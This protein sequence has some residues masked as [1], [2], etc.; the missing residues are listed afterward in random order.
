MIE[1]MQY[2][3][4][5]LRVFGLSFPTANYSYFSYASSTEFIVHN[6]SHLIIMIVNDNNIIQTIL[7]I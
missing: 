3:D 7:S 4:F 6:K 5:I 1:Y 2:A